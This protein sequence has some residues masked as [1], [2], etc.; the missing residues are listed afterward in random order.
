MKA[1]RRRKRRL[2]WA[3]RAV[4]DLDAIHGYIG[5]DDTVAADRWV[6]A[7]MALAERAAKLPWTGRKVPELSRDE[8]REMIKRTYRVVYRVSETEVEVLTVFEG[9]R[10]F[11]RGVG[12][13][14]Q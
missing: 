2:I 14:E 12:Q 3:R 11:P 1:R 10:T 5:R 8:F 4:S 7:L 13:E 9:H 6:R